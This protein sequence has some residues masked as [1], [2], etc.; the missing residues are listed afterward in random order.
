MKSSFYVVFGLWISISL[1][2]GG[3]TPVVAQAHA[4]HSSADGED[5][6]AK[7]QSIEL[8]LVSP[9]VMGSDFA[10]GTWTLQT[11]GSVAFADESG[12]IYAGHIGVG[13]HI[14]DDFSINLEAFGLHMDFERGPVDEAAAYGLDLFLRYHFMKGDSWTLFGEVGG[15]I[16]QSTRPIPHGGT[17]FNFRPMAGMG[18][19]WQLDENLMLMAGARWLHISNARKDGVELNPGYDSAEL[20]TGV[21]ITF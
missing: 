13:Y 9:P 12:E 4:S 19:T 7:S 5:P 8:S 20:Y 3:V 18:V 2:F 15:G 11:Y 1:G 16:Q 21:L 14:W 10:Q 17:H 6:S